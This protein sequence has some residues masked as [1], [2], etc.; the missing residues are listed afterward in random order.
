MELLEIILLVIIGAMTFVLFVFLASAWLFAVKDVLSRRE[1]DMLIRLVWVGIM[2]AMPFVGTF[3]YL[4]LGR[5]DA[6]A[7]FFNR[8]RNLPDSWRRIR[9]NL[10]RS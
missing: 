8:W 1:I 9:T 5:P 10:L 3:I 6:G 2:I 4:L 7:S